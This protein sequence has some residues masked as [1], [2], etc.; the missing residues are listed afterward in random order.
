M[1]ARHEDAL[2]QWIVDSLCGDVRSTSSVPKKLL[3]CRTAKVGRE[4]KLTIGA[5]VN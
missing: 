3:I 4:R 1:P 5:S 2:P